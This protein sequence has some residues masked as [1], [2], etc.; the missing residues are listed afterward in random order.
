MNRNSLIKLDNHLENTILSNQIL[1]E[2]RGFFIYYNKPNK[3]TKQLKI[4]QHF[5]GQCS[6]A[7]GKISKKN[8]GKNG[9][10]IGPFKDIKYIKK[11]IQENFNEL[12]KQLDMGCSCLKSII[13]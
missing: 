12:E 9:V 7:S 11:F 10:W 5:C 4:H 13:S 2:K 3:K 6:W 8:T 1:I